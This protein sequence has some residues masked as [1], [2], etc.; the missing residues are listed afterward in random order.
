MVGQFASFEVKD[1]RL[2]WEGIGGRLL[3]TGA[4]GLNVC[5][6]YKER[7]SCASKG[8]YPHLPV[9]FLR[10]ISYASQPARSTAFLLF[11]PGTEEIRYAAPHHRA[12]Y[13]HDIV[14]KW[15]MRGR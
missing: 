15:R 3:Y 10:A 5:P 2:H 13:G 12:S 14:V 4:E 1:S 8:I 11:L 9:R 6:I 7:R